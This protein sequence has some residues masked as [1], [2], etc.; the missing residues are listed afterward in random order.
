MQMIVE[1][2]QGASAMRSAW[3]AAH[4]RPVVVAIKMQSLHVAGGDLE[5]G[6][7]PFRNFAMMPLRS[8][9]ITPRAAGHAKRL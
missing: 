9:P 5:S 1:T 8:M 7:Q 2:T 6:R 4:W 3:R